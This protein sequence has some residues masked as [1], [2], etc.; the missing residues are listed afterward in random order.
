[1]LL[2]ALSCLQGRPQQQAAEDLLVLGA[3]GLQ[4]TPGCAPSPAFSAWVDWRGVPVRSHDGFA[5]QTLR[6]PVWSAGGSLVA[7]STSVHPPTVASGVSGWLDGALAAGAAVEVMYGG[8]QLADGPSV[9]AALDAGLPLAVDVS[10]LALDSSREVLPDVV[11][12]RL[13]ASEAV[14]EVHVSHNDGK[15]DRHWPLQADTWGL[16]WARERAAAGT[17][18]VLESYLHRLV[19]TERQDV[20]ELVRE[21][22]GA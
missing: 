16:H 9:S 12:R 18:V 5:W 8:W 19:P 21:R 22:V 17:P 11:R 15:A 6:R 13:L 10:H 1:M 14:V 20:V 2:L 4:L 3:D 7:T